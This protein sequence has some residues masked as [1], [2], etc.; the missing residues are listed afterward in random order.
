MRLLIL[1]GIA[2]SV[3]GVLGYLTLSQSSAAD[4]REPRHIQRTDIDDLKASVAT[5]S[6]EL[7]VQKSRSIAQSEVLAQA[8]ESPEAPTVELQ[9]DEDD[10]A[11]DHSVP[12][13]EEELQFAFDQSPED[14]SAARK[15]RQDV[16]A[17]LETNE[18]LRSAVRGVECR[19]S[20]CRL[21][22]EMP[23]GASGR[24]IVQ[25]LRDLDWKGPLTGGVKSGGDPDGAV[26]GVAYLSQPGAMLK[27]PTDESE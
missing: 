22:V 4:H 23:V 20:T 5:L 2:M 21:D 27:M 24:D 6:R 19:G 25:H 14:P 26:V 3:A 18:V 16:D 12:K 1:G 10:L 8:D 15:T 13:D 7:S 17:A 9:N 11:V